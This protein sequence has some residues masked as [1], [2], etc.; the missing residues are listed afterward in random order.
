MIFILGIVV[1]ILISIFGYSYLDGNK[2]ATLNEDFSLPNG[3]LLK[4]G[5]KIKYNASFSEG[6]RQYIMY[7]NMP[8]WTDNEITFEKEK[9]SVIPHWIE[10]IKNK[11]ISNVSCDSIFE[12]GEKM[13]NFKGGDIELLK[14]N[15]NKIIPIID[16]ANKK[17]EILISKL[18][19]SLIISKQGKIISSEII[20]KI[21][22]ELKSELENELL[23]MPNWI[24]GEV[25]GKAECMK[26][27]IPISCVKWE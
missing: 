22:K 11:S 12:Y 7:L 1:G 9:Y 16:K 13:P 17:S 23:K 15:T 6:F 8:S 26:I 2:Y 5:T 24:A 21:G 4:K 3:G 14:Y 18:Q 27:K 25:N 19:Y 20:T 10:P